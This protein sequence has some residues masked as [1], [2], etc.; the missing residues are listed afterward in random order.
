MFP[1]RRF[2]RV[3]LAVALAVP[4][5]AACTGQ[6]LRSSLG[7]KRNNPDEFRVV[8]RPPL[9]VPPV[10]HLRPPAEDES[11]SLTP[12]HDRGRAL[13]VENREL[14]MY[15]VPKDDPAYQVD[16]AVTDV[17]TGTLGTTGE[18]LFLRNA[19][20]EA[21]KSDIRSVLN[22]ENRPIVLEEKREKGFFE[23]ITSKLRPG[24]DEPI[25]DARKEQERIRQNQTEGKPIN[26]GETPV[27]D[28]KDE[29][30]LDRLDKLL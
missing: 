9:S 15:Q 19:G 6:E 8:S 27:I 20:A 28:P 25:V 2:L 10:Y 14:P 17:E 1:F 29:S 24:S 16:T 13:V 11:L 18:S 22:E 26:E 23:N 30:V 21:A 12:A 7:L 3:M 5:L 4:L